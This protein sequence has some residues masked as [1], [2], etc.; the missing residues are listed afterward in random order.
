TGNKNV[1][2]AFGGHLANDNDWGSGKGA[3]SFPGGSGK[4][5]A[6]LDGGSFNN[7]SLNPGQVITNTAPLVSST[8]A[9]VTVTE[10]QTAANTRTYSD[11]NGDTVTLSA[12]VG[13]VTKT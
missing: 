9:S 8:N 10:G 7:A 1:V 13:T 12:S 3:S 2:I 4:V 5:Y 6:S 11:A